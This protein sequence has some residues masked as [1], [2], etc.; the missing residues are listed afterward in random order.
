MKRLIH[1]E[2]TRISE[3][4]NV[5]MTTYSANV[6]KLTLNQIRTIPWINIKSEEPCKNANIKQDYLL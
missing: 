6:S 3:N 1:I 2:Y 4:D 5:D